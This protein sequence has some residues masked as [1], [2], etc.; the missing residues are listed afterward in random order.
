MNAQ[1]AAGQL[2]C[3]IVGGV[4]PQAAKEQGMPVQ[5]QH[6]QIAYRSK[7]RITL[8]K[9]RSAKRFSKGGCR[10]NTSVFLT[11]RSLSPHFFLQPSTQ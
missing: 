9:M 3:K 4:V 7:P 5:A 6:K 1:H 2:L 10:W 8:L 11:V